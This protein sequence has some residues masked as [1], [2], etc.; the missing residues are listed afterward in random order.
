MN[1]DNIGTTSANGWP[2]M[3]FEERFVVYHEL[4]FR[5]VLLWW[6]EGEKETRKERIA[7]AKEYSLFIENVHSDMGF[8]NSIWELGT[9]GEKKTQEHI[10]AIKDC[11]LHGVR[12]MV[13]HLTNGVSPPDISDIGIKRIEKLIDYAIKYDVVLAIENVRTD[14]HVK[15]VL[16]NYK[17]EH[18]AF[19]FDTGHA[20]LWCKETDWLSLY[21]NRLAAIHIHDNNG[22]EDEHTFP[23]MGTIDWIN[24][25][26][27]IDASSYDG[28]LTLETEYKG[29]A[30]VKQFKK[31]LKTSYQSGRTLS[32]L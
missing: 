28:S 3:S 25:M 24:M 10:Q 1:K 21:A 14:K 6:G 7:L 13:I 31:F 12:R 32:L 22:S 9:L 30:E 11:A 27:K 29:S 4:G 23:L 19:C 5:S 8:S 18:V 15:Y 20:N 26:R 16:D 17:E 2:F